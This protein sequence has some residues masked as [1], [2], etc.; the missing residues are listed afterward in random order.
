M[1]TDFSAKA[2]GSGSRPKDNESLSRLVWEI[3]SISVYLEDIRQFL[4][5]ELGITGPQWMILMALASRDAEPGVPVNAVSKMMHVDPSFITT[6]S[7]LLEKRGLLS[8]QPSKSDARV[9]QMSLTDQARKHFAKLAAQWEALEQFVFGQ[10]T[11]QQAI[12]F[13]NELAALRKRLEM[14]CLKVVL[15]S[16]DRNPTFSASTRL[17]QSRRKKPGAD[18][19][20]LE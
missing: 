3:A 14:A 11:N 15:D 8:R 6:Q 2:I 20:G 10:L 7:K 9:V 17:P 1:L 5:R 19:A 12:E 18:S 13:V 16:V 4:A